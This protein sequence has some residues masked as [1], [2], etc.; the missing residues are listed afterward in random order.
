M[1]I[2]DE[3]SARNE[4]FAQGQFDPT[5]ELNP[6]R[7]LMVVGCVDPRV[8]PAAVLGLRLGEGAVIRNVGGR[9]TPATFATFAMLG[10]VGAANGS[11]PGAGWNLVVLHHTDCGMTD[12]AA[13]P[14]LLATYFDIPE[15]DL[16]AKSV[17]D[18]YASVHVDVD[19]LRSS[20][21][22]LPRFAVSGWVYDVGTGRAALV[23]PP[24]APQGTT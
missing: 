18:P 5:M 1:S 11:P 20:G 22:L 24:Q 21:L 10:R 7:Q 8:D 17:S 12:L 19:L 13:H 16:P 6:T 9:I 4:A 14:D 2:L 15:Q 3:L 23:V